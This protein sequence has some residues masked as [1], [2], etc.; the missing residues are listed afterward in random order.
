[1][2]NAVL[3]EGTCKSPC[4]PRRGDCFF[5]NSAEVRTCVTRRNARAFICSQSNAC[6]AGVGGTGYLRRQPNDTLGFRTLAVH[7][8]RLAFAGLTHRTLVR[9]TST[10]IH[11]YARNIHMRACT[12]TRNT[13]KHTQYRLNGSLDSSPRGQRLCFPPF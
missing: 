4:S 12:G 11:T 6:P 3:S 9:E 10:H 7:D 5:A 13:H 2:C 8:L 1:V